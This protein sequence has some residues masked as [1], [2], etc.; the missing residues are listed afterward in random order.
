MP[1]YQR[2]L[3]GIVMVSVYVDDNFCVGHKLALEELAEDL[4]KSGLSV[5][6]MEDMTNYLSCNIT[7]LE[8]GKSVWIGQPHLIPKLEEKFGDMV[9]GLQTYTTP[10]T[11][12]LHMV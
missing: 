1:S 12:E 2:G 6:V 5:K 11:P 10:G 4:K 3:N 7:F 9:K 8:D